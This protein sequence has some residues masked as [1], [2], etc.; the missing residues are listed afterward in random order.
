M[1]SWSVLGYP[2]VSW[3][4]Q[5][6][7]WRKTG[8]VLYLAEQLYRDRLLRDLSLFT[9]GSGRGCEEHLAEEN[10]GV[11]VGGGG[12]RAWALKLCGTSR[13]CNVSSTRT[14]LLA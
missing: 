3:G 9:A 11:G 12:G 6:D 7:R 14:M 2:G 1:L 13:K 5:I 10:E 8:S 4:N